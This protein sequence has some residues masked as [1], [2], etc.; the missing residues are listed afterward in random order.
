MLT[1]ESVQEKS[2]LVFEDELQIKVEALKNKRFAEHKEQIDAYEQAGL[3]VQASKL[4]KKI[5]ISIAKDV[6][7][8][9]LNIESLARILM[10]EN[11]L[12]FQVDEW[13]PEH[14]Y[15]WNSG[16][17][18]CLRTNSIDVSFIKRNLFVKKKI[19]KC[20]MGALDF[21]K[22]EIPYGV[23]LRVNELKELGIFTC[24]NVIAPEKVWQQPVY[25]D[26]IV[27][28]S[29]AEM[30]AVYHGNYVRIEDMTH[31]FVAKW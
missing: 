4:K 27:V 10:K 28:A 1:L 6:G 15:E 26:P 2:V 17:S 13:A 23:V 22:I 8:Q 3:R 20:R 21:L 7:F 31:F 29:I 5:N 11:K 12:P 25:R 9:E 16:F 30:S 18:Q 24:F 19:S 14:I